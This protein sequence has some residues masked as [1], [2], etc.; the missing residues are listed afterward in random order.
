MISEFI[1]SVGKIYEQSEARLLYLRGA[2][3]LGFSEL[4]SRYTK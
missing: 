2:Q 1:Q 3:F 4:V